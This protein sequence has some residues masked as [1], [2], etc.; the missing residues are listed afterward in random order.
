MTVAHGKIGF[1]LMP[2][3][4]GAALI[5]V[6]PVSLLFSRLGNDRIFLSDRAFDAVGIQRL[7]RYVFGGSE[8]Q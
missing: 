1:V 7:I 4:H 3:R 6:D 8:L 5:D 2:C